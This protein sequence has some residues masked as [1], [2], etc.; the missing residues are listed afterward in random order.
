MLNRRQF[1][2]HRTL[3][4]GHLSYDENTCTVECLIRNLSEC[5]AGLR[6]ADS[7]VLPSELIL[8]F[9]D[10]RAARPGFVRWRRGNILGIEFTASL[11]EKSH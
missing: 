5:G 11:S 1:I 7:G 3:K 10:G 8:S 2:R 6:V 9:D 4:G